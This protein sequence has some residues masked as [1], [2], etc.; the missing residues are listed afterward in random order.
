MV[1]PWRVIMCGSELHAVAGHVRDFGD[2]P[3][4]RCRARFAPVSPKQSAR[5][6]RPGDA[7]ADTEVP[8]HPVLAVAALRQ[9]SVQRGPVDADGRRALSTRAQHREAVLSSS[10]LIAAKIAAW[11]SKRRRP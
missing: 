9:L 4:R 5:K 7:W 6:V 8:R 10:V 1:R 3:V 11:L 2:L